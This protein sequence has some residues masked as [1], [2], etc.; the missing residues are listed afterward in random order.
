[1]EDRKFVEDTPRD[2]MSICG[3]C[4]DWTEQ[5]IEENKERFKYLL[6]RK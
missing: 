4:W 2:K 3:N 1:M 5:D 6:D